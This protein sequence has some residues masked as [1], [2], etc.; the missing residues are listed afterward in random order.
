MLAFLP[1]AM[2][3]LA[4]RLEAQRPNPEFTMSIG[5]PCGQ[6][7]VGPAGGLYDD[8]RGGGE[9]FMSTEAYWGDLD[10]DGLRD[11]NWVPSNRP[12][13]TWEVLITTANNP[14]P[15]FG[16][17]GWSWTLAVEGALEITDVTTLGTPAC[18]VGM[19]RRFCRDVLNISPCETACRRNGGHEMT[20]LTGPPHGSGGEENRGALSH[21]VMSFDSGP[22][23]L[24]PEGTQAVAKLRVAGHFPENEGEEVSGRLFFAPRETEGIAWF[25]WVDWYTG[26]STLEVGNPPIRVE[27]CEVR[28]RATPPASFLR[29]DP[30]DDGIINIADP[31]WIF[32]E[33]FRGGVHTRCR[34]AADCNGDGARDLS[35][36]IYALSYLFQGSSA[37][38]APF[39]GCGGVERLDWYDCPFGSTRCPP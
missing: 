1:G 37:P 29:C 30:T 38:P 34:A 18:E 22:F 10:G 25:P 23:W 15:P 27:D 4:S 19:G 33:L 8:G 32:T 2:I 14:M 7:I 9:V 24:N 5:G 6:T 13:H 21:I 11:F 26:P 16:A 3:L 36:G 35:D 28:F 20:E 39:P 31:V 17:T 12:G